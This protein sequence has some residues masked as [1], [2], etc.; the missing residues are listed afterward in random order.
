MKRKLLYKILASSVGATAAFAV[1]AQAQN[2][3]VNGDFENAGGFTANPVTPAGV[4]AGWAPYGPAAAQSDMSSSSDSPES[5]SYALIETQAAGGSWSVPGAYQIVQPIGGILAGATYIMSG[6]YLS[7][8]NP[9]GNVDAGVQLGFRGAW[10]GTAFPQLGTDANLPG[11]WVGIPTA[12]NNEWIPFSISEVAP[13]GAVNIISYV[14]M[15]N[16]GG[17]PA[18]D[19]YYD[20]ISVTQAVPEPTTLALAGLGG[21]AALS[22]IRRRKS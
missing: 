19:L 5:G 11:Y 14:Q 10:N 6:F 3:L 21:A 22:L 12:N 15:G 20:N 4:N 8:A 13:A 1:S 7:D 2:L 16:G 9:L 17:G 18:T